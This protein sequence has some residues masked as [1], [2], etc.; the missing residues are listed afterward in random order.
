MTA[1]SLFSALVQ[2]GH[3]AEMVGIP[4]KWYP[5]DRILDHMLASRLL[6]LTESGGVTI[7][8]VIALKFPAYLIRHPNKVIWLLHQHR[9]AYDLWDHPVAG[10]LKRSP[11]GNLVRRAITVAD[12]NLMAEAR[13]IFTN[14]KNVAQRLKKWVGLDGSP[15]Y[16]PPPGAES[17]YSEESEEYLFFPSRL[18]TLKRQ[19]L[20]VEA[21]GH[22]RHP[23]RVHFAGCSTDVGYEKKLQETTRR[24]GLTQRVRW[25]GNISEDEKRRQYARALAVVFPPYDEDYGYVTLE[26]MLSSRPVVTCTD[27]GGPIELVDNRKTGLVVAPSPKELAAAFDELWGD[28]EQSRRWGER[29]R[30]KYDELGISWDQ[31]VDELLR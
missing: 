9:Q 30:R 22:T 14:S 26:G 21:L 10:D 17:F 1:E 29:G 15:L 25:L 12:T 2:R 20:V 27:S 19:L 13:H 24:L 7:D 18:D 5:Q 23:V 6:D 3:Q 31:V 16:C 4:F 28:R 11:Q 8:R